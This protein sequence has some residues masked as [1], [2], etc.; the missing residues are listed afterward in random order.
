MIFKKQKNNL[1]QALFKHYYWLGRGRTGAL[2][3]VAQPAL[4]FLPVLPVTSA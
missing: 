3:T 1:V 2:E 4:S